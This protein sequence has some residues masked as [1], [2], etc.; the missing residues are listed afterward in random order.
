MAPLSFGRGSG[1]GGAPDMG[2]SGSEAGEIE[3]EPLMSRSAAREPTPLVL[4][5]PDERRGFVRKVY[6]LLGCQLFVTCVLAGAI[7]RH[8]RAWLHSSPAVVASVLAASCALSLAAACVTAC[9]P[10]MMR[11]YP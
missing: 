3:L 6:S 8:G 5:K 10:D 9:C 7:V 2:R 11:K 1:G 4:A